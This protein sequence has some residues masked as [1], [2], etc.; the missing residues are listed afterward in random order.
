MEERYTL[1]G[2][3]GNAFSVMG[4]VRHAMKE[5][6]KTKAE[7]DAYTKDAMSSD[8]NHL[9]GV[10]IEMIDKLNEELTNEE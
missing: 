6:R 4:Y 3:D 2:V 5:C 7:I 1:V 8:Y 9:L 10:S